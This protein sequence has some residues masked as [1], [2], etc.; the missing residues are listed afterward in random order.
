MPSPRVGH[1]RRKVELF[2]FATF[3]DAFPP[4][5]R[6]YL[7]DSRTLANEFLV[8]ERSLLHHQQQQGGKW[9][10]YFLE[11]EHFSVSVATSSSS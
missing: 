1:H 5:P 6:T 9:G 8:S 2:Y 4:P 3:G 7:V 11:V 10:S